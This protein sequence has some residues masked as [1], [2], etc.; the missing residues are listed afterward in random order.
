MKSQR[1]A[2][3]GATL[4]YI[5]F[6]GEGPPLLMLHGLGCASSFEYPHVA[7]ASALRG[8]HTLLVDLLGFGFSD[9]PEAFGYRVCDHA[10]AIVALVGHR[11]FTTVNLYGHSMGGSIAIEVADALGARVENLVLSEANLDSGGG[12][13]SRAIAERGEEDYL[14]AGHDEI[15]A[16][17]AAGKEDA[18]AV[19]MRRALPAAVF[20]GA[21][22]LVD[23]S[24]PDW[25]AR[26]LA[27]PARKAF[28]FGERSLPD[29]DADALAQAG[30]R[31]LTVENAGHS[32]GVENPT[33][34]A[35]AIAAALA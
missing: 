21:Q 10:A 5:E 20:R 13:F 30:I 18:W 31:V 34:L 33:G 14:R 3:A 8:R 26:F 2:E 23:G 25:R 32:M 24:T 27:H 12:L 35:R 9:Q 16:K 11:Q 15:V 4:R 22:S 19:T 28:V 29:P 17:A 6:E 7:Q 1:I